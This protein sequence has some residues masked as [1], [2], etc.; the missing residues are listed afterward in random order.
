MTCRVR[1]V[2][3]C[4]GFFYQISFGLKI[5]YSGDLLEGF[6]WNFCKGHFFFK[7]LLKSLKSITIFFF[8][9]LEYFSF[10]STQ[11]L[12][13]GLINN[14]SSEFETFLKYAF[15]QFLNFQKI[16]REWSYSLL[17]KFVS[18]DS[19]LKKREFF[20]VLDEIKFYYFKN[21]RF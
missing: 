12:I 11:K 7:K 19:L 10:I 3:E 9:I 15:Y 21:K 1:V 5:F 4:L 20:R 13:P 14:F 6:Y 17:K 16:K 18:E 2:V 8:H